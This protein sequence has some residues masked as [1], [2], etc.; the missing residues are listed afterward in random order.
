MEDKKTRTKTKPVP[1]EAKPRNSDSFIYKWRWIITGVIAF[2]LVALSFILLSMR[3]LKNSDPSELS[4]NLVQ[5]NSEVQQLV[6]TP[7][8]RTYLTQ[9]QL[10]VQGGGKGFAAL[11]YEIS[12]PKGTAHVLVWAIKSEGSW[13]IVKL[14]VISSN[15]KTL[16]II[17]LS[18]NDPNNNFLKLFS[19]NK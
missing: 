8:K 13:Q 2:L 12:G 16:Q 5:K 3:I 11:K 4:Y 19:P 9:G 10:K 17:N 6:G 18:P 14:M 7:M 1:A 15:N